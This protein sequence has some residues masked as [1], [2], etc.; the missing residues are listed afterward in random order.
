MRSNKALFLAAAVFAATSIGSVA[1]AGSWVLGVHGGASVPMGDFADE[2][3]ANAQTGW[4][5]GG[6]VD[7]RIS[8]TW[9]FGIDGSML[10]NSNGDEGETFTD[11]GVTF[12]VDEAKFKTWQFGAHA[13]MMFPMQGAFKPYATLGLG[14]YNVK[15]DVTVSS[16]GVSHSEESDGETKFG[17]KLGLGGDWMFSPTM[18]IGLQ[19]AY[20]FVSLDEESDGISSLQFVG[21]QAG[22]KFVIP[23]GGQ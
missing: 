15:T 1:Y 17:G 4:Q 19:A 6:G 2:N 9:A 7:Y 8:D 3:L 16:G 13:N 14:A 20:N 23:T 12:T 10:Q 11:E 21:L 22:L 18:G 5:V